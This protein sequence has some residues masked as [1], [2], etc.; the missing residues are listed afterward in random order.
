MNIPTPR[1]P[2]A[3]RRVAAA[4]LRGPG[5]RDEPV[6]RSVTTATTSE[7]AQPVSR[8]PGMTRSRSSP[9]V[10][11]LA[12]TL[13]G[14]RAARQDRQPLRGDVPARP[15]G[16]PRRQQGR[17]HPH[18]AARVPRPHP[19]G[20]PAGRRGRALGRRWSASASCSSPW[21]RRSA[22]SS[23]PTF[24]LPLIGHFPPFEWLTEAAS[25]GPGCVGI[26]VLI[27]IRQ[28]N[29]PRSAPGEHGRR[30]RFFGST[31]VAGL[32]RRVHDP[33]R[34]ALHPAAARP[35]VRPG[36][37]GTTGH[38]SATSALHFPLT[39]WLGGS[40]R[41]VASA[42]SRAPSS[43]SRAI[44]ILISMAWMITIALTP[45]MGVAWHR[46]LAFLNIW[47]K[48]HADGR[49][50]LGEL[51]PITVG[52]QAARLRE[53]S[54]SSTRTP[55]LGRRQGRGLHLEGPAR[56][57]HLHRVRPLPVASA[58]RGTPTSRSRPRC[59]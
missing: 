3:Q 18:A 29:H 12:V 35:R 9:I 21:S 34:H 51:Q 8:L 54:R 2:S 56:L 58:R 22:S 28:R 24:A 32:L 36:V 46:F 59:S 7:R 11:C 16:V 30:S 6:T 4:A 26:L 1:Y 23:S 15:A 27:A 20:A 47:F 10:V 49:T 19:D 44:K 31:L 37:S 48:R 14:R 42:P 53:A 43:S 13:V 5:R 55:R 33:R 41:A 17:A 25:P 40:G 45:T 52:G 38:A 50:A 39:G 57:L